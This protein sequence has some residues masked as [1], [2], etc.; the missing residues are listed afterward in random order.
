MNNNE[1]K[2]QKSKIKILGFVIVILIFASYIL[3]FRK[4]GVEKVN[5][6]DTFA[7]CLA[8]K[9][10]IMYGAYWCPHCQNEKRAFGSSWKYVPYVE[11]TEETQKCIDQKIKGYP[12]WIFPDGKRLEGEQGIEKLSKESRCELK[13]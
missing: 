1:F 12:T 9:N 13:P 10:V 8:D 5:A 4:N 2:N 7:K 6:L 3:I 11:C